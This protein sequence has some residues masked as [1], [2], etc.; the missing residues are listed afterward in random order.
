M[1]YII[2][3][4]ILYASNVLAFD[5]FNPDR[6][7]PPP[8][9]PS[10]ITTN[11][12]GTKKLQTPFTAKTSVKPNRNK[13]PKKLLP[14]KDFSL[15]GTSI[16]GSKRA[17]ILI[18]PD[19]KEFIQYFKDNK[20]TPINLEKFKGYFLLKVEAREAEIEYPENA[21]CRK[22]REKAGVKCIEKTNGLTIA[23][24]SL[25]QR[26]ALKAPKP[27]TIP[28]PPVTKAERNKKREKDI[29]KRKEIYKNF[30]RKVIK[31]EDVPPGMR[32]VRT[33]FGDRLVPIK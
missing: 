4:M 18:A 30:K 24:L 7:K 8:P 31:D 1:K 26:K 19:K 12:L 10:D 6:G 14:Q 28:K 2:L 9:K 27:R 11:S 23:A 13:K 32:V 5:L 29:E 3:V 33:P 22:D 17:A 15:K 21:P 16:I 25:K 20:R